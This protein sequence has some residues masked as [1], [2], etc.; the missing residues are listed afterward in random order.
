MT[1]IYT[2]APLGYDPSEYSFQFVS[3]RN[4]KGNFSTKAVYDTGKLDPASMIYV[5]GLNYD[6]RLVVD[7]PLG[8]A[9]SNSN[10]LGWLRDHQYYNEQ[11]Y[12]RY[13]EAFS[14]GNR[15][16]IRNNE[17][18]IVDKEFIS[19]FPEYA[20]FEDQ[21][22]VH[23]HIG[24]G[25]QAIGIPQSLHVDHV[26]IHTAEKEAGVNDAARW[27]SDFV[28]SKMENEPHLTREQ[29][30]RQF[31]EAMQK[32]AQDQKISMANETSCLLSNSQL[33]KGQQ[34]K[35]GL[36]LPEHPVLDSNRTI[37]PDESEWKMAEIL[38]L[39]EDNQK[40]SLESSE[41]QHD[42]MSRLADENETGREK[43][44]LQKDALSAE[45]EV[46]SEALWNQTEE[47]ESGK[48]LSQEKEEE[49]YTMDDLSENREMRREEES[50]LE[51]NS[52]H[53]LG[54]DGEDIWERIEREEETGETNQ[55]EGYSM[56]ELSNGRENEKADMGDSDRRRHEE[57]ELSLK[58]TGI[59]A[60]ES[61]EY[62]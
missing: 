50:L 16:R 48:K 29:I 52:F 26:G 49:S 51:E 40:E 41:E 31:D 36:A 58:E 5:F 4:I 27:H 59:E 57:E 24:G 14:S 20:G 12:E 61:I 33:E 2:F 44:S 25:P 1:K 10:S 17:T 56:D 62:S 13:P 46:E 7:M 23:H 6:E 38:D 54:S 39:T 15:E 45:S 60:E 43:E 11:L 21:P 53:E 55:K 42:D 30:N 28:K 35:R 8:T 22:L 9:K 32:L 37:S 18:M 47:E 3:A 19:V 34:W